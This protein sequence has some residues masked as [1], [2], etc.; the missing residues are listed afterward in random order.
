MRGGGR[1][2]YDQREVGTT[3]LKN[4]TKR[5]KY[6]NAKSQIQKEINLNVKSERVNKNQS[7]EKKL[8]EGEKIQSKSW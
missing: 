8:L 2:R 3:G 1:R 4:R 6:L 5:K 7:K